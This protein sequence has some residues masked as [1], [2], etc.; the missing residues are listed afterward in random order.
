M[1]SH[2]KDPRAHLPLKPS[3]FAVLAALAGAPLPGIDILDAVNATVTGV[4]LFGPGT[5][6]RLLRE[7]RH[8]RL[9]SRVERAGDV[10]DERQAVH[11]LTVLG[12]AVL[13]AEA[14]R[15]RRTLD[16]AEGRPGTGTRS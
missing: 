5:L 13:R 10:G 9:I 1:Q 15:L 16:L 12:R 11:E 7:L 2:S 8:E 6:Y 4:P 14:A 3:A